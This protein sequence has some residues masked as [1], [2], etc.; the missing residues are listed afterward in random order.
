[1][2]ATALTPNARTRLHRAWAVELD[3]AR[4][5]RSAGDANADWSHLER[6]HSLSQPLAGAH[7]GRRTGIDHR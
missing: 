3:A 6:A 5:A 7:R 1:M 4:A 2:N